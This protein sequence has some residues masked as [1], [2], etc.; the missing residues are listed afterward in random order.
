M[1]ALGLRRW[2]LDRRDGFCIQYEVC[3]ARYTVYGKVLLLV[4]PNGVR[5]PSVV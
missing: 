2:S 1:A 4:I 3:R 5:N